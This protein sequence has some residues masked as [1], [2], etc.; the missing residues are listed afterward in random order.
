MTSCSFTPSDTP[1]VDPDT[2][3]GPKEVSTFAGGCFWC[4][5]SAFDDEE[6]VITAISGYI[7]G[8]EKDPTYKQ[9]SAGKTGHVE[10]VQVTYDPTI[11]PYSDIL[12]IFWRQIDPTDDGGQFADRGVQYK[13][14]IFYHNENQKRIAEGSKQD[15][16]NSGRYQKSIVTPILPASDFYPAEAY[17]QDYHEKNPIRY[18]FYRKGSGRD[19]YLE[20]IWGSQ[21]NE[22]SVFDPSSSIQSASP[23]DFSG[24]EKEYFRPTDE[25]I[26]AMLTPLQYDV[27]QEEGTESAFKNEYNNNK[28]E[29]IYVDIISG[30]PLFS[31]LDKFDSGTGW[32][33]FTKPLAKNYVV[34]KSDYRLFMKRTEVR[35]KYAD[36]HLGH[37][38]PDGPDSTGLRYCVNSAAMRF[39]PKENMEQEGY[40]E[41]AILFEES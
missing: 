40:G 8:K 13:T 3:N 32:P 35:S 16:E 29:G 15:L 6:G 37:V 17:H 28:K 24:E 11:I 25:E 36:S 22:E 12:S 19:Q 21:E 30:E 5:E 33:S 39:I 9:V 31:S 26:E 7:G 14:A 18:N 4:V 23:K 41:Y 2:Y 27:T 38:F 34:E 10:S 1:K 20:E